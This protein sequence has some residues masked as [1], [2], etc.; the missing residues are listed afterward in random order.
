MYFWTD[1]TNVKADIAT[2]SKVQG[3][4]TICDGLLLYQRHFVVP[5]SLQKEDSH[6]S[7]TE[8][9]IHY[10]QGLQSSGQALRIPVHLYMCQRIIP[11]SEPL[12][13][14]WTKCPAQRIETS[15]PVHKG[16]ATTQGMKNQG[17]RSTTRH[18]QHNYTGISVQNHR[19]PFQKPRKNFYETSYIKL[20]IIVSTKFSIHNS[21]KKS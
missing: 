6:R 3:K 9:L 20:I 18:T 11:R 14:Y 4:L 7:C 16:W 1:K 2:Y 10:E 17:H 19:T 13:T 21:I 5:K 15:G 8:A 12:M